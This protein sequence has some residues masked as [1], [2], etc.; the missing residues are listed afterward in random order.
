MPSKQMLSSVLILGSVAY[1]PLVAQTVAPTPPP[2]G[3]E[4]TVAV[5]PGVPDIMRRQGLSEADARAVLDRQGEISRFL[6]GSALTQR[7]D[8]VDLVVRPKPYRSSSLSTGTCDCR[9]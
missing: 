7:S 4:P 5:A 1:S 2:P 9:R 3:A 8:F 6:T